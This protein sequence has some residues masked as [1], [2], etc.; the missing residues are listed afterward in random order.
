MRLYAWV[1][2]VEYCADLFA[3][4]LGFGCGVLCRSVCC[5]LGF[6]MWGTVPIYSYVLC[7][8]AQDGMPSVSVLCGW[9]SATHRKDGHPKKARQPSFPHTS[10]IGNRNTEKN[11][12]LTL[13]TVLPSRKALILSTVI[14]MILCLEA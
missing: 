9:K 3:V 12:L 8:L 1:M 11:Y 10:Y 2:N 6:W 13:L 7:S 4:C 14:S 5:M